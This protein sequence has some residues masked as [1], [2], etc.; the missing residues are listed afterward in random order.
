MFGK[1]KTKLS[2]SKKFLCEKG[3]GVM[4]GMLWMA[5]VAIVAG[6]ISYAMWGS[7]G[8]SGAA[9]ASKNTIST[10]MGTT[11]TDAKTITP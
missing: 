11:T 8:I 9:T 5:V 6:A 7:A 1:V 10:Q 4:T 2:N 3:E